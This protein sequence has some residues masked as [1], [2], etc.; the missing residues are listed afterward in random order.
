MRIVGMIAVAWLLLQVYP[1]IH[2]D[3][4]APRK[5]VNQEKVKLLDDGLMDY[6]PGA[7]IKRHK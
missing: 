5:E 4:A 7:I 2:I 3:F 6:Y 1:H